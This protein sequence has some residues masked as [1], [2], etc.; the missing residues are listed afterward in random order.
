MSGTGGKSRIFVDL[1]VGALVIAVLFLIAATY[2]VE[3]A[4]N[5]IVVRGLYGATI[6]YASI[7]SASLIDSLP[8]GLVRVNG[9]GMGFMDIGHYRSAVLGKLRLAVLKREG[10]YLILETETE[11]II[12]GLGSQRNREL[13]ALVESEI[14]RK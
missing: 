5:G 10:P 2:K 4:Q 11:K 7:R 9:I 12:L 14:V 8:V 3:T 6:P 1:A 13:L